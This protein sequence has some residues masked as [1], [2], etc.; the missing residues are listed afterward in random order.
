MGHNHESGSQSS[1]Q[2][3]QSG[4]SQYGQSGQGM[5]HNHESGS[6]SSSQ[7]GQSGSL[8]P[9][10]ERHGSGQCDP[11]QRDFDKNIDKLVKEGESSSHKDREKKEKEVEGAFRNSGDK[12]RK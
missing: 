6:Q 10:N 7:Y 9:E 11:C 8:N 2:Y 12:S 5:G 4:Q 1:S 3:G